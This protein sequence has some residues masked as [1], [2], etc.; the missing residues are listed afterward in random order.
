MRWIVLALS[1]GASITSIIHGVFM[2]FGSLSMGG[3]GVGD[4]SPMAL[5]LASLPIIA[6]VFALI[7]G[8]VAFSPSRWGALFLTIATAI[9]PFTPRDF[10][11]YGGLYFLGA[12]LCFFLRPRHEFP[13]YD[14]DFDYEDDDEEEDEEDDLQ[15]L[16]ARRGRRGVG[17]P[18]RDHATVSDAAS[19][20]GSLLGAAQKT[21]G[22][23]T[24][25]CPT[26]GATAAIDHHFC[27]NCGAKLH[28]PT[29]ALAPEPPA[30]APEEAARPADPMDLPAPPEER[31]V[32]PQATRVRP[33]NVER[34]GLNSAEHEDM[35]GMNSMAE[36]DEMAGMDEMDDVDG[37]D[38]MGRG[39]RR[40]RFRLEETDL[41]DMTNEPPLFE[42]AGPAPT[43]KVFVR[44]AHE[45]EMPRRPINIEPDSSYQE[46]KKYS[47][48]GK[49]RRRSFGRRILN[50]I[51]LFGAMGGAL[52]FLL[53]L[54]KLPPDPTKLPPLP[55]TP[56]AAMRSEDLTVVVPAIPMPED[57]VPARA[58]FT[59]NLTLRRGVVTGGNVN[60]REDHSTGSKSLTRLSVN[61]RAEVTDSWTGQ[62]G[63]LS[64]TWYRVRTGG[65]EGWVYGRYF[66]PLG[67]ALP[68]EYVNSLLRSFGEDKGSLVA[69]L[70]Q[71][72]KS[73]A[74]SMEWN[75]LSAAFRGE[76]L[77]RLRLSAARHELSNGLKTGMAQAAVVQ[78]LGYP[79]D[80][81]QQRQM[82][83][84]PGLSLQL[85]KDGVVQSITVNAQ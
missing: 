20:S 73:S 25:F 58:A 77:T 23:A 76:S 57:H 50:L 40:N 42:R 60:L 8:I 9:C 35:G 41:E 46:F 37:M 21:R 75:G 44:P 45:E 39:L 66:Q 11:I 53:G 14:Y 49:R 83:Y 4:G 12:L 68:G 24:K 34:R 16:E 71:P 51:L 78:M 7:G 22:R 43:H 17:Q 38:T 47:R 13:D 32:E 30:D 6:A 29:R 19:T 36:M 85:N 55:E 81:S 59:P 61:T 79:T 56:A 28:I 70:G 10:W 65:R 63:N 31:E 80:L 15:P 2:L 1:L 48:R 18:A 26:C 74:A 54:R 3:G 64:G 27:P 62:S 84:G 52:Y 82:Q 67:E 72:A 5:V 69:R 33:L